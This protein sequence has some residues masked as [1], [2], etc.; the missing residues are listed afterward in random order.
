MLDKV[1]RGHFDE[2]NDRLSLSKKEETALKRISVRE[3][4]RK[5]M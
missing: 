3:V 2:R 4:K 5:S 1:V